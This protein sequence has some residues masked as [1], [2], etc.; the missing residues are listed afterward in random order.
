MDFENSNT[1]GP[2]T[3]KVYRGE[4]VA[5]LAFDLDQSAATPDFVGFAVRF[6]PPGRGDWKV[7]GNR[8]HFDYSGD[9]K[10][11]AFHPTT[12]APFQKY[13]WNHVPREV[14]AGEYRYEATP[15]Y[16]AADG[17]LRAGR[18]VETAI[19]LA[20]QTHEGF[21]NVGFTRGF[22]SSQ[23]Y[24]NDTRFK[25]GRKILPPKGGGGAKT[26]DF[27]MSP[28]EEHYDW[29]GFEAR[30][31]IYG[32]LDEVAND[33]DLRLDALLYEAR[34]G[35]I[36]RRLQGLGSRVRAIIDDHGE[37]GGKNS[38]ETLAA[39]RLTAS[40]AE[41]ARMHFGRQQHNKVFIVKRRVR[42]GWKAERVLTGSTNFSMRGLYIQANNV[43]V[44]DDDR[45]AGFYADVFDAYWKNDGTAAFKA[46]ELA[47]QWHVLRDKPGSRYSFCVS[48]HADSALSLDPVADAIVNAKSSVLYSMVFLNQLSGP[49]RDGLDEL[50]QR[51]IFSYGT[52]Q[53]VSGLS[54]EKPDGSRAVLPFAYIASNAPEPFRTEWHGESTGQSNMVHH[55]F[56]VTDFNGDEPKVFTGSSNLAAG[57]ERTNGDNLILIEDRRVAISYAIEALRL[58]DHFHFRVAL[59]EGRSG[60]APTR[61]SAGGGGPDRLTLQKPPENPRERTWFA[62]YYI[63]GHVK[64]SDRKLFAG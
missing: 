62:P 11:R 60:G 52:A 1:S 47:G 45:V 27:D 21:L 38:A 59:R 50:A 19:S 57:G 23:A 33:D 35:E 16:M 2:T 28:F 31:L 15:M 5:L 58:F 22:A 26:L 39:K 48:P 36:V 53:R 12:E 7:L 43:L 3:L 29:L 32:L 54:L 6:R 20:P 14:T 44:F 41:V 40:G 55:K 51:S 46:S 63:A 49:V 24:A 42:G 8:L 4:G 56:V 61:R 13:R 30:R 37:N 25:N 17:T 10:S 18:K 64:E 34:E 9:R